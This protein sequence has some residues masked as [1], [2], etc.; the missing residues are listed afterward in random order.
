VLFDRG[1]PDAVFD[2]L[3]STRPFTALARSVYFHHRGL[4]SAAGWRDL[5]QTL[6][7]GQP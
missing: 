2:A 5:A 7:R 6:L 4:A 3:L 1:V